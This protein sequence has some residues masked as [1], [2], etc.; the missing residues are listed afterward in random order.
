MHGSHAGA[1]TTARRGEKKEHRDGGGGGG[2]AEGDT[3]AEADLI[4]SAVQH[5][6]FRAARVAHWEM[7]SATYCKLFPPKEKR[8]RD[9]ETQTDFFNEFVTKRLRK[10]ETHTFAMLIAIEKTLVRK[11]ENGRLCLQIKEGNRG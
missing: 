10:K 7:E 4:S 6:A 8:H 3:H 1:R 9:R 2:E 11:N 5:E